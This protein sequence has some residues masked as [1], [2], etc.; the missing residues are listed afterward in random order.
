MDKVLV[1][2][3][4]GDTRFKRWAKHVTK[5]LPDKTNGY[6]FEG[7][8]VPL[9]R[10]VEL[11]VGAIVLI[12]NEEGSRAKHFPH[13]WVQRVVKNDDGSGSLED[14]EPLARGFDWALK[15][16]DKVAPLV[17]IAPTPAPLLEQMERERVLAELLAE[18]GYS[19]QDSV[20]QVE[21]RPLS[22]DAVRQA[23]LKAYRAG[24]RQ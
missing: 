15:L 7:E 17:N 6:A 2:L 19:G 21:T 3:E 11:P 4:G 9:E 23:L 13:A 10:L 20:E 22:A 14:V 18:L 16:R 5:V 24:G 8:F 1:T 12:Y